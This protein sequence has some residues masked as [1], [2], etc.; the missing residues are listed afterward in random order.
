MIQNLSQP[1]LE[2]TPEYTFEA[3]YS[4]PPN[5]TN[6]GNSQVGS[7]CCC[8]TTGDPVFKDSV[9]LNSLTDPE[10]QQQIDGD[11][12]AESSGI[13]T[14]NEFGEV[15]ITGPNKVTVWNQD[16][17]IDNGVITGTY[18]AS[19]NQ[20]L[21]DTY[22]DNI[23]ANVSPITS[24]EETFTGSVDYPNSERDGSQEI[25]YTYDN[26]DVQEN[27]LYGKS[28]FD[29]SGEIFIGTAVI[30]NNNID[31]NDAIHIFNGTSIG[32]M[33]YTGE[34]TSIMGKP[35]VIESSYLYEGNVLDSTDLENPEVLLAS[36]Y[37][38]V[39]QEEAASVPG[40]TITSATGSNE[41]DGESN[42]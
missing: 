31:G 27:N 28:I 38:I 36:G 2:P 7:D 33:A 8:P 18:T 25:T 6:V 3:T 13:V 37:A 35:P 21:I 23:E 20:S 11:G 39:G 14:R 17:T 30:N 42:M 29:E 22:N 19:P 32:G 40:V 1:A 15:V 41:N 24:I 12:P 34:N 5:E 4:K 16:A 26:G 10:I 9:P